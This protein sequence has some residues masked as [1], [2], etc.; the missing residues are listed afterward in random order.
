MI[1]IP[2][3]PHASFYRKAGV[4]WICVMS[5]DYP[6]HPHHLPLIYAHFYADKN[7]S[8]RRVSCLMYNAIVQVFPDLH[9]GKVSKK[10]GKKCYIE[11]GGIQKGKT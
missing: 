11:E 10:N 1:R 8:N 7:S 2:Q 3:F 5:T 9:L 6:H 4:R